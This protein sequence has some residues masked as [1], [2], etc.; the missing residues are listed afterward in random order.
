MKSYNV[1][2]K[3]NALGAKIGDY[4]FDAAN[5]KTGIVVKLDQ[6]GNYDIIYV[7]FPNGFN[8]IEK[9][10]NTMYDAL[11]CG[12]FHIIEREVYKEDE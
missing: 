5:L 1:K 2:L 8:N 6:E 7:K 3:D 9:R 10:I 11:T 12:R 4:I